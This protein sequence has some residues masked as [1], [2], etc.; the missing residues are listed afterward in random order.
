MRSL[1]F[2]TALAAVFIATPFASAFARGGAMGGMHSAQS[3]GS[4]GQNSNRIHLPRSNVG[5]PS[6]NL[7]SG[8]RMDKDS[9]GQSTATPGNT[10]IRVH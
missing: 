9:V 3:I 6:R 7:T 5:T 2:S 1:M 8:A 10:A 4:A